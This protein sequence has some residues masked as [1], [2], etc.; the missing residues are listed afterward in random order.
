VI[1]LAARAFVIALYFVLVVTFLFCVLRERTY[2]ERRVLIIA[3]RQIIL[4]SARTHK[5][6]QR[7]L[8]QERQN[9]HIYSSLRVGAQ[10]KE[11]I[12][13]SFEAEEKNARGDLRKMGRC[14][15]VTPEMG[16][17]G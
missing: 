15:L 12:E 4:F 14:F 9:I 6:C 17:M 2:N 13:T 10:K 16:Q 7:H 1:K 5:A 8:L 11:K 3:T